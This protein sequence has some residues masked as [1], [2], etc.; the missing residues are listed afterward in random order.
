MRFWMNDGGSRVSLHV[1]PLPHA[2]GGLRAA[3]TRLR[4]ACR[5]V[6]DRAARRWPSWRDVAVAGMAAGG[7]RALLL[8]R[9][10]RIDRQE[11][12]EVLGAR[13]PDSIVGDV[14]AV[15]PHWDFAAEDATELARVRRGVEPL[16]MVILPQ[17][18]ASAGAR[19]GTA[20]L[21]ASEPL[22]PMPMLF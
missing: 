9:H 18:A 17:R 8:V 12:A 20:P 19:H 4:R 14:G 6:R 1:L 11:V 15:E 7:G 16:R 22:A 2:P 5:D 13:W 3:V 10:V 21:E